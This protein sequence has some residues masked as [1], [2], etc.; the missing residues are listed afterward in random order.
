MDF[1]D[2]LERATPLES[3]QLLKA[4]A[5]KTYMTRADVME[6]LKFP[7][8]Y[9]GLIVTPS[10]HKGTG[11]LRTKWDERYLDSVMTE[12]EYLKVIDGAS[13]LMA[14]EYSKKRKSDSKTTPWT[15]K[16][17]FLISLFLLVAFVVMAFY[18][19]EVDTLWYDILCYA[20][21]AI[22]MSLVIFT[23][24]L[25]LFLT[26]NKY[27]SYPEMVRFKLEEY[28]DKKN[29]VYKPKGLEWRFVDNHYWCELRILKNWK[30][31]DQKG[32]KRTKGNPNR[33]RMQQ[34]S[35]KN[36]LDE[37]EEVI[38]DFLDKE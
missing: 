7:K 22:G 36:S 26:Q 38:G 16:G 10:N 13:R 23:L 6:K 35:S 11:F 31:Y 32:D 30:G 29:E 15:V 25:N 37:N 18:M 4:Q 5:E 12:E 28:F 8:N 21:C 17:S 33:E 24:V 3:I 1:E 14:L 20:V 34:V 2:Q 9:N 19:P 27:L